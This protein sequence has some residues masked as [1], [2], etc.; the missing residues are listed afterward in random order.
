VP[1]DSDDRD[2]VAPLIPAT[3]QM[4][5]GGVL[6]PEATTPPPIGKTLVPASVDHVATSEPP[7]MPP[8]HR[9]EYGAEIA[10]GGM[11]RV[12]E[13][14]DTVLGRTVALKEALSLDPDVVR[15]FEREIRITARLEHPSIVPV[16]DAG[17]AENGSPFYVMRKIGGRPL[18]VLVAQATE[19]S[20]RL[21]L[22][23]HIVAAAHAV[24]HAHE[25]GVVHRDI[26]PSNILAG[27]LGE[28]MVIDWGLAK[29]IGEHDEPRSMKPPTAR[30]VLEDE[31]PDAIKT[32][33]GIVFGTPGFMAP[34]Q[35]RGGAPDERCD[36]YALGATLYHSLAR[37]PPHYAKHGGDMMRKALEGPPEALRDLVPGVPPELAAI[38]D[39]ALAHDR[40]MRYP[41]AR[42]LAD[43]LQ[44]FLT[45]QLVASHHYSNREKLR[46]WVH[47]N[48]ALVTVTGGALALLIF[49]GAF[50]IS[51][52]VAARDRADAEAVLARKA[53][54]TSEVQK[55]LAIDRLN[56]VTISEARTLAQTEATRAVALV[57]PLVTTARWRAVRDVAAEA[58]A[59]GVA[60]AL[61]ASPH[62]L[63]LELSRDG[64]RAITAGDDGLI[65][66]YD[67]TR[68]E[69]VRTLFDA[70]AATP[71]RFGDAEHTVVLFRDTHV[72]LVDVASGAYRDVH[73]PTS[74]V[75]LE[76]AGPTAYYTDT[77]KELWKLD[78]A[79][80]APTKIAVD[81]AIEQIVPSP[82]GRWV[83]IAGAQHLMLIDRTSTLPPESIAEGVVRQLAWQA[84]ASELAALID[85]DV[86]EITLRPTPTIIH[87]YMA[88]SLA[89]IGLTRGRMVAASPSGVVWV[90]RQNTVVRASGSD[91]SLG[92]HNSRGDTIVAGRPSGF[93]VLTD[94][95]DLAV[96]SPAPLM[97]VEASSRSS[98]VVGATDGKVLVWEL[99]AMLP[100]V[101]GDEA[102]VAA[103]FVTGDQVVATY[104]ASPAQ[105]IDLKTNKVSE[106]GPIAGISWLVPAP[107][108]LRAVVIDGTHHGRIVAP[109]GE[110]V[111]LGDDLEAAAFLD[112]NRLVLA[113]SAG[114][115]AIGN[116]V[117]VQR[118]A[119]VTTLVTAPGGWIAAGFADRSIWRTNLATRTETSLAVEL[120]TERRALAFVGDGDVVYG[121]GTELRVWCANGAK[122][123]IAK[124]GR[125]I[126]TVAAIGDGRVLAIA[127]DGSAVIADKLRPA[128]ASPIA[129]P[130]TN[131]SLAVDGSLV[132]AL[133]MNGTIELFDPVINERWTLAEP[134]DPEIPNAVL[135]HRAFVRSVA[136]APDGR[137]LLAIT[138]NHLLVWT[139]ALPPSAAATATWT[140]AL[141]NATAS[142][143]GTLEWKL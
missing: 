62:T 45:G 127:V 73:A 104:V 70:H 134:R 98:F 4:P 116:K 84:D 25:R 91:F 2:S 92:L 49:F 74:I 34:E 107:D 20:S 143:S 90:L 37:K 15:R 83:A 28:T 11:G 39:M 47:K 78:L 69:S 105:W 8:V 23:P 31:D 132:G 80:G 82:D 68:K 66:I 108:G 100:R 19:L 59:H 111:D 137:R 1:G 57:K 72:T 63:S 110:P 130:V 13:A 51:R 14:T 40:N 27:E 138:A 7:A 97:H 118:A 22:L 94:Q 65:R 88:G 141:S 85:E 121:V 71:A 44:R 129:L 58:R 76:V 99:D 123:V 120:A 21:A 56:L 142:A 18:E 131:P 35:L 53:Q 101:L 6:S 126:V 93:T 9:Y 67:L 52:I 140:E 50:A 136:L 122:S 61:P 128:V 32:R 55:N 36:V 87:R 24:A 139:V 46:R 48:R 30:S 77:Q 33:A 103:A 115:I 102:M 109:V 41:N 96:T 119:A 81:E 16:H 12:I 75:Q 112:D 135:T 60:F 124:L 64:Q 54:Q 106:L 117:L 29:A 38:V 114:K 79:G 86:V 26:K 89:A 95:G 42:A 113:T 43:D 3:I 17:I 10:R 125:P 133:A 5:R